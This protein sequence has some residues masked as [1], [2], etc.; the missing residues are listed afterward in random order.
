[1]RESVSVCERKRDTERQGQRERETQK[2][3]EG[4]KDRETERERE[5]VREG[6]GKLEYQS[7]QTDSEIK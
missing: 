7:N 6:L 4:Y 2:E 3:R 1:M 5:K